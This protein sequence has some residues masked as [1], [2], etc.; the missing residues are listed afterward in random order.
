MGAFWSSETMLIWKWVGGAVLSIAAAL[1]AWRRQSLSDREK[2][3]DK[4]S[5]LIDTLQSNVDDLI[6]TIGKINREKSFDHPDYH[7]IYSQFWKTRRQIE[8]VFYRD[9]T[10]KLDRVEKSVKALHWM[11][12][13]EAWEDKKFASSRAQEYIELANRIQLHE[14]DDLIRTAREY[15]AISRSRQKWLDWRLYC[16]P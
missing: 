8:E 10:E 1:Y 9:V 11:R 6:G 14:M 2:L 4:R 5:A 3:A 12:S 16:R 13:S 7:N 15:Y